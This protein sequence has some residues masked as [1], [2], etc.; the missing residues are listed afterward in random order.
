MT[1]ATDPR[2][3]AA[4]LLKA[5]RL[6][7]FPSGQ[8]AQATVERPF[9]RLL[10]AACLALAIGI[11]ATSAYA[12]PSLNV[13][14]AVKSVPTAE[15]Q[16]L[17]TLQQRFGGSGFQPIVYLDADAADIE[18]SLSASEA[19]KIS[20]AESLVGQVRDRSG[21]LLDEGAARAVANK[22]A[23]SGEAG[24]FF[25]K[26]GDGLDTA[27]AGAVCVV[28]PSSAEGSFATLAGSI[29]GLAPEAMTLST[30][31]QPADAFG[32]LRDF[33]DLHET[34]HCLDSRYAPRMTGGDP[35]GSLRHQA[36][37]Y[38]DVHAALMMAREGRPQIAR[39]V[40]DLRNIA[41]A[42][43]HS[44][45]A[46][47]ALAEDGSVPAT[48][49]YAIGG[50]LAAA[51]A[52]IAANLPEIRRMD[53]AALKKAAYRLVDANALSSDARAV[54]AL[55]MA[56]VPTDTL[57][58]PEDARAD[59]L[60]AKAAVDLSIAAR[61]DRSRLSGP[62]ADPVEASRFQPT[63]PAVAKAAGGLAARG[64]MIGAARVIATDRDQRREKTAHM[65]S[66]AR[67]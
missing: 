30:G 57:G 7:V 34:A 5:E 49:T 44:T 38:A 14:Q 66:P 23:G 1:A 53:D 46:K 29:A 11:S 20:L 17:E 3:D 65:P 64:D 32:A 22:L 67:P 12:A 61:V 36:E 40:V 15:T 50:G 47:Q 26:K 4:R 51:N 55:E 45:E 54:L 39:L 25:F 63:D 8:K 10:S 21:A 58:A 52:Y 62:L 31:M 59:A 60:T 24:S 9:R 27:G 28:L 33:A 48:M 16:R 42:A 37:M 41:L 43:R 35:D 19:K 18:I 13:T 2:T 56:G 6:T